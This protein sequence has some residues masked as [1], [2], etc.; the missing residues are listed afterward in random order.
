MVSPL[1]DHERAKNLLHMVDGCLSKDL[2]PSAWRSK[3]G[4]I[5]TFTAFVGVL[6]ASSSLLRHRKAFGDLQVSC[7]L[8]R[9]FPTTHTGMLIH[10]EDVHVALSE[11][12][13]AN[14]ADMTKKDHAAW[15]V[16]KTCWSTW[17]DAV[18]Q[19]LSILRFVCRSGE[20]KV[21]G[22]DG[23]DKKSRLSKGAFLT[24]RGWHQHVPSLVTAFNQ[25]PQAFTEEFTCVRGLRGTLTEKEVFIL[26]VKHAQYKKVGQFLLVLGQGTKNR[27]LVFLGIRLKTCKDLVSVPSNSSVCQEHW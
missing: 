17:R 23:L 13:D 3:K 5:Y 27:A 8:A 18:C 26:L 6:R 12:I 19:P 9:R 15:H 22:P 1:K 2:Q 14:G 10:Y 4:R 16:L 20:I 24:L 11:I 25:S 7:P 21:I